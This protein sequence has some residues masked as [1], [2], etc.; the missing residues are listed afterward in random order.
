MARIERQNIDIFAGE[1]SNNGVFGSAQDGSKILSNDVE[2]LQSKPAW[3]SGWLLAVLGARKFPPLEE[4]QALMYVATYQIAYLLQEG[5]PEYYA[6]A[7]YYEKSIVRKAGT[8]ELYGS[9]V[10]DN[11]GNPLTDDESWEFL[12]DISVSAQ[13]ATT[14]VS[15]IAMLAQDADVV[16]GNTDK[17]VTPNLLKAYGFQTGDIKDR[18]LSSL[19]TGWIWGD[20]KT[21]GNASSNAT[22]RANADTFEL[23]KAYWEDA[24]YNYTGTTAT[25]RALQVYN[26]AG[27][28][29]AK[30][31]SAAA[32][33]AAD[34]QIAVP[35][36]RDRVK[37]G[38][39]NMGGTP[40]GRLSGAPG[41]VNGN[42]LGN[43]GGAETHSLVEDE[44]GPH[45][46]S[47]LN[48][49]SS[50]IQL[51]LRTGTGTTLAQWSAGSPSHRAS[52]M[53]PTTDVSG[54]GDPHNNVQPT[55][56]VNTIIKL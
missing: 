52:F 14:S 45:A 25:G 35:D 36:F 54:E 47:P 53:N 17:I 28:A 40:A 2:E 16:S 19:P 43:A 44:N 10:D 6:D 7:V 39:G 3:K 48:G 23:F 34:R 31:A 22:N 38:R 12:Q 11:T 56:I 51:T 21:I 26:S 8:Y 49:D 32:D 27:V 5:I 46:H 50:F 37:A 24:E 9:L 20:G 42:N 30:G 41:G 29:V 15:G 4:F 1:A 55:I 13:Q 18:S 33:W